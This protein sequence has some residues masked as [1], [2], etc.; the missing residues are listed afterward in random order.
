MRAAP[1][2]LCF[3]VAVAACRPTSP[4]PVS[5]TEPLEQVFAELEADPALTGARIGCAVQA[6]DAARY[7]EGFLPASNLKLFTAAAVL[8][9]ADPAFRF[10]TVL[11]ARGRIENGVLRGDLELVGSGDPTLGSA[12]F[13]GGRITA[14]LEAMAAAVRRRGIRAVSGNVLG[15]DDCQ[16]DEIMG[17]GWDWSY[18]SAWYAAQVSGLSFNENCV[19]FVF[20]GGAEGGPVRFRLE[21]DTRYV[22]IRNLVRC[23]AGVRP[24]IVLERERATNRITLSGVFPCEG[25]ERDWVSVENPTAYAATVLKEALERSGVIVRG[26]ALDRDDLDR[27]RAEGPVTVVH[28]HRS[29][30]LAEIIV[31]MLQRSQNLY[32]EQLLRLAGRLNGGD[33]SAASGRAAAE[34]ALRSLGVDPRGLVMADGSGLSRLDLVTPRHVLGLLVG[35]YHRQERDLFLR[36]LPSPG[37]GT[38]RGRFPPGSPARGRLRAKTG[39]IARVVTLSGYL[40][41][42]SRGP[43][44]FTVLVNDFRDAPAKVRAAVDRFVEELALLYP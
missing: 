6:V 29:P 16:P 21:P 38:L 19:D 3:L 31:S 9:V 1:H 26:R 15:I 34:A 4:R 17:R 33:G 39:Y 37:R 32:A 14:S 41:R 42:R 7:E 11:R 8:S 24:A 18:Q 27:V 22:S 44:A 10:E 12:V 20:E 43:L 35:M 5:G 23:R 13:S 30:P 40:L 36:A 2:P 28:V 25:R